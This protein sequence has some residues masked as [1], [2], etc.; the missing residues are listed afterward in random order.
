MLLKFYHYFKKLS[1]VLFI[2]VGNELWAQ[3]KYSI[4][5]NIKDASNGE[6]LIGATLN[7]KE[8]NTGVA[9]NE[10]GFFS[11]TLPQGKY[12]IVISYLGYK[13]KSLVVDLF[14]NQK[15]NF[16]LE[17]EAAELKEVVVSTEKLDKNVKEVQMSVAQI[18]IKQIKKIPAFLG[19]V[20]VV[21]AV[22]LLPGVSTVGEGASGF[23]V[24]GGNIDQ[25]LILLDEAPVYNSSH[26]FGFFSVFN[27]DAVKDVKLYK[28]GIPS[29]YGGRLSSIL[30]VRLK[31]G[32]S[33]KL[34]VKGG[35]GVI[36]SRL[37]VEAPIN[38]GKGSFI[39]AGRR[40]YIDVL[41]RPLLTGALEGV[42]AYFYDLTAKVNY[43]VSPKD[44]LFLSGYLGR[45]VF[46]SEFR[47]NWGNAT[48]SLRWNHVY[49]NKV[50]MN[51]TAFYSNYDYQL[52][53]L[54]TT[55]GGD[56]FEWK[57]NIINYS[58]KPD[59]TW[60]LNPKNTISFGAQSIFYTFRPGNTK[61]TVQNEATELNL[62]EKYSIENAFYISNEQTITD[63]LSFRYGLRNSLFSYLGPGT[64]LEFEPNTPGL[65]KSVSKETEHG[66]FE[67]IKTY[68]NLEPRFSAKY[69]LSST[70][71]VKASY[72]RTVQNLHLVS[73]TAASVPLDVW[74]PSTNNIKPQLGDQVAAGY[75]KNFGECNAFETS[76]E[77]FYKNMRNQLEYIDEA[78]LLLNPRL[79]ADLLQGKGRAYGAE[80]YV[81]KNTGRITG[82]VSYTLSR[83][84]RFTEGVNRNEWYP[85][86]FDR[87]HNL[88][89]VVSF[90]LS[91]RV[92]IAANFIFGSGTPISLPANKYYVEGMP[93]AHDPLMRRNNIRIPNT[94]R[95]DLSLTLKCKKREG[96]RYN[97]DLVFAV[98]N[99]YNRRNPFSIFRRASDPEFNFLGPEDRIITIPNQ[100]ATIRYSI[101]GTVIP[102]VT[103]NFS[104]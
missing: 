92:T 13:E 57:S 24:R 67:N 99:A 31:D 68:N 15:I 43:T 16:E 104:F 20:D 63:K 55:T 39:I 41:A 7:V 76:I 35:L 37:S 77:G 100:P 10:Y 45:D 80:L 1:L 4:S 36:F 5:G 26:L 71:S 44:K 18:D 65:R 64:S 82:F 40:S 90:E 59:F 17:T 56:G 14:S 48:T 21:R 50:F 101:V 93:V 58:L 79:E 34:A 91:E 2:F 42:K 25:N 74:S 85:S 73:N 6:E 38:K 96:R 53:T 86:R 30:D 81:K 33:K 54:G 28:G 22:Q 19:E 87:P 95:L 12:T 9:T 98:Y 103:Y 52:G 51:L 94:H 60:Y 27:P 78:D 61:A 70:S 72:D 47:F 97:W 29:S 49:N 88:N 46:G 32:N 62:P 23:N 102:S 84:E 89:L 3:Q 83:T 66:N 11:I 69:E 75:F 8:L